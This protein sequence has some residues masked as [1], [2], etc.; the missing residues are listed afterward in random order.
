MAFSRPGQ[1]TA[2]RG[3]SRRLR[4]THAT[5]GDCR[6]HDPLSRGGHGMLFAMTMNLTGLGIILALCIAA[7]MAVT[8]TL[9]VILAMYGKGLTLKVLGRDSR[10]AK[11]IELG[12]EAT[13]GL[14]VAALG[15]LLLIG[16]V[17]S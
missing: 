8:I 7:G 6:G 13:A 3:Y 5:C 17:Y 1:S 15:G 9:V 2:G 14:L 4:D 12:I 16:T 11:R 10:L